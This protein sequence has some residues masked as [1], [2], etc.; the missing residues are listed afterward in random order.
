MDSLSGVQRLSPTQRATASLMREEAFSQKPS[1][2]LTARS[3]SLIVMVRSCRGG[4]AISHD[5]FSGAL[6]LSWTSLN[7]PT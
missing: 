4:R 3:L 1:M 5:R 2:P 6:A 7:H